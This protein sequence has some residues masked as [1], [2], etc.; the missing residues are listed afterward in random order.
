MTDRADNGPD[1]GEVSRGPL[2]G[3]RVLEFCQVAAGPFC[4]LLFADLGADVIKIEGKN[5]DSMRQWP[6]FNEGYS[7]NFASLNRSKRSIMLDLK[8]EEDR[9]VAVELARTSDIL[10]ENNRP[11]VME[12]LGLDYKTLAEINPSL[13]YCSI[14][15]FGQTGPRA[16]E[17]GFDL[18]IQAIAGVMGVTGEIGQPPVKCGVPISDFTAGLYAAYSALASVF[19][20][21]RTGRGT[22]VDVPMMGVTLGVSALQ[23]SQ[24]FG[25]GED[26]L[27]L[28]SAHPRNAP[29][30]AFA[31]KDGYFVMAAGN[32]KLWASVCSIVNRPDLLSDPRFIKQI[33]RAANQVELKDILEQEFIAEPVAVW[34]ERFSKAGVPNGPINSISEALNDPQ[35]QHL[36]WVEP[37]DLPGGGTTKTFG[38]PVRFS[39]QPRPVLKSPPALDEHSAEIRASLASTKERTL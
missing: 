11:G 29:Y 35:A 21:R 33:D 1:Q 4:G 9:N 3:V 39:G 38:P 2:A 31:A 16:S 34:L 20:A 25:T 12:R 19:E 14:S 6:P 13:V 37:L 5:G 17:G 28:G 36:G 24:Y 18:T 7:E 26:P 10:I 27:P 15:A 23:T 30:Q 8:Q 32:E 22:H